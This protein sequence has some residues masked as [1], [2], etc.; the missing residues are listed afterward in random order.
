VRSDYPI[1][2]VTMGTEASRAPLRWR[3]KSRASTCMCTS[4]ITWVRERVRMAARGRAGRATDQK[5]VVAV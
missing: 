5:G 3:S 1:G 2:D 4:P